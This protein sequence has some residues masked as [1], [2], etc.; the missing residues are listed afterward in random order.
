MVTRVGAVGVLSRDDT[1]VPPF[2]IWNTISPTSLWR[3]YM[4]IRP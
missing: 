3:Y 2:L 1:H 4:G